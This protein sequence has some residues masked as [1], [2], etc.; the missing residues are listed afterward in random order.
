MVMTKSK[1]KNKKQRAAAFLN[2]EITTKSGIVL[3]SDRGFPIYQNPDYPNAKEDLLVEAAGKTEKGI[4]ELD[5]RVRIALN[6]KE[7]NTIV[8]AEDL[9]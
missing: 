6:Y 2:W 8:K 1:S 7:E 3:K 9:F 4:L 5:M